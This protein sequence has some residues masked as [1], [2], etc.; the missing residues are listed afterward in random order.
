MGSFTR[1]LVSVAA[2]TPA[3]SSTERWRSEG[4]PTPRNYSKQQKAMGSWIMT[5]TS[6]TFS[7]P[8]EHKNNRRLQKSSS[9]THKAEAVSEFS[10]HY[11]NHPLCRR[12]QA[13]AEPWSSGSK[14]LPRLRYLG[15]SLN[16]MNKQRWNLMATEW[17]CSSHMFLCEISLYTILFFLKKCCKTPFRC[18]LSSTHSE[19]K[20]IEVAMFRYWVLEGSS[21]KHSRILRWLHQKIEQD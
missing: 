11:R 20:N 15:P 17:E 7:R 1:L 19:E 9:C 18:L 2:T 12:T 16:L 5:R 4:C 8:T 3:T 10:V 6:G 14:K 13:A 21:P